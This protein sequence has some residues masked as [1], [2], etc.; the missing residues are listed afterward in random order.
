ML[1]SPASGLSIGTIPAV[2]Q[3]SETDSGKTPFGKIGRAALASADASAD[4]SHSEDGPRHTD[5]PRVL[6]ISYHFPPV[7]GAGVQRPVKFVKYLREF[8]WEP[9]VLAAANPSVP[10]FDASLLRDLPADLRMVHA[11]TWEPDYRVKQQ[12]G[13]NQPA[14]SQGATGTAHRGESS[15]VPTGRNWKQALRTAL[16][17][18]AGLALQPD[19]QLLWLPNAFEAAYRLLQ[20]T[21]HDL[22]FATAPPYSNLLLGGLLKQ[23][24]GLPL[25]LDYRDEWDLSS[26]Y[27]ENS[28]RDFWSGF[29]QE[30]MQ[31]WVLRQADAVIATT[32]ASTRRVAERAHAARRMAWLTGAKDGGPILPPLASRCIYNGF[33]PVDFASPEHLSPATPYTSAA[34]AAAESRESAAGQS[35]PVPATRDDRL[36]LVYTGTLW[37]LTSIAPVVA[38]L[39]QLSQ[40]APALAGQIELIAVGRK[41]PEQLVIV[42]RLER[43]P[44]R[45]ERIDYLPHAQAIEWMRS[46]DALLLLLSDVPGADR[47]APAKLFE[48]LA[49][50]RPILAVLPDGESAQI[51]RQ[52]DPTGHYRPDDIAGISRWLRAALQQKLSR[53][54]HQTDLFESA[55]VRPSAHAFTRR[56]LTRQLANLFDELT[57]GRPVASAGS[58]PP[59]SQSPAAELDSR[60]TDRGESC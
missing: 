4:R 16:R 54:G 38:A 59:A 17:S 7:G 60:T 35:A 50:E 45:L 19:A 53:V 13:Q 51:V 57:P 25:V 22:I 18:I 55:P 56:E 41:T 26:Q 27:L 10:V 21:P 28:R 20:Q 3:S 15:P 46:A 24:T 40:D 2:T 29:V 47:V 14:D 12:L 43:T 33:D 48:Y 6:C 9:T 39:E 34:P 37:N 11:R 42:N 8:G 49:L 5:R 44:V 36:R 31:R 30:R 23:A 1:N 52:F 58:Q 32:Q